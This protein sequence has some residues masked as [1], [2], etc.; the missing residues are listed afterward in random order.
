MEIPL[1]LVPQVSTDLAFID[2]YFT[3][4]YKVNCAHLG[5]FLAGTDPSL[6]EGVKIAKIV[7]SFERSARSFRPFDGVF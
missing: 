2:I 3:D 4:T 6:R 7:I 5:Q 1:L